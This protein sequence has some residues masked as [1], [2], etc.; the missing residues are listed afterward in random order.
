[1]KM[2]SFVFLTLYDRSHGQGSFGGKKK[3]QQPGRSPPRQ[4][5]TPARLPVALFF[6]DVSLAF[7]LVTGE[8]NAIHKLQPGSQL[9]EPRKE[10]QNKR[11]HDETNVRLN[12]H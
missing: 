7:S 11:F 5:G 12:V 2:V 10:L 9:H 3:Q 4:P 1:M 8:N 6:L